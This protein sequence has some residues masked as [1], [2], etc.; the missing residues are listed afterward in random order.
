MTNSRK[1]RGMRTQKVAADWFGL[2]GW[3]FATS[4]GAGRSGVDIENMPGLAPEVK[5]RNDLNLTGFLKQA[6]KNR[7]EGLPFVIVRPNG[8]GETRVGEW[9]VIFTLADATE[10]LRAAGFGNSSLP[11]IDI[12]TSESAD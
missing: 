9:A 11:H 1:A 10:L 7:G 6:T 5:A 4:T 3:P 2:H 12:H 8:Y